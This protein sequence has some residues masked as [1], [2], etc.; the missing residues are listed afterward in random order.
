MEPICDSMAR[1]I[2]DFT[3]TGAPPASFHSSVCLPPTDAPQRGSLSDS[4]GVRKEQQRRPQTRSKN[5]CWTCRKRRVKCD[6]V[7]PQ[8]GG[9]VRLYK[10][11]H[12]GYQWQLLDFGLCTGRQLRHNTPSSSSSWNRYPSS[13]TSD[14]QSTR[15]SFKHRNVSGISPEDTHRKK[16]APSPQD[17]YSISTNS[18]FSSPSSCRPLTPLSHVTSPDEID[19]DKRMRVSDF[20][21]LAKP[22]TSS[23]PTLLLPRSLWNKY[24]LPESAGSQQTPSAPRDSE[25]QNTVTAAEPMLN[26]KALTL[27]HIATYGLRYHDE[28]LGAFDEEAAIFTHSKSFEPLRHAI[29]A[30]SSLTSALRGQKPGLVEAFEHYDRA[31]STSVSHAHVEPSLLYHL[32]FVLLIFDVCCM[33]QDIRGP[34]MWSQHLGHLATL[35]SCLRKDNSAKVPANLLWIVLNLDVQLCLAGNNDAGSCVRAYL[36]DELFL[37]DL[38]EL[39]DLR[40]DFECGTSILCAAVYDLATYICRKFAE[41]SQLALKMRCEK[42]SGRGSAAARHRCIDKFYHILYI[43]WTFR[44]KHILNLTVS[45]C[46]V[47]MSTTLSTTLEYALL[48]YSTIIVYLHTSM[49]HDQH[50]PSPRVGT[51]VAEHCTKILSVA[52]KNRLDPHQCIFPLFLSGYASKHTLQ[53]EQALELIKST[54]ATSLSSDSCRLVNLLQLIYAQQTAQA[55]T[56]ATTGVDWIN[57]SRQVG[58]HMVDLSL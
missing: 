58:I 56:S 40:H 51:R 18:S 57:L 44:Y 32:H 49:Y 41:L 10:N 34:S 42:K 26:H 22:E 6:E 46:E 53:K 30:L 11:C 17:S 4:Q 50:F 3:F 47:L 54:W 19:Q 20:G 45:N 13:L 2:S 9:C 37:P 1:A 38:A 39:Q 14:T 8:C 29:R 5:G 7:R 15:P 25:D 16:D 43:E 28:E 21:I 52:S 31:V 36:A 55:Q 23:Q 48:Q 35:A 12:Y 24:E 27:P 33:G